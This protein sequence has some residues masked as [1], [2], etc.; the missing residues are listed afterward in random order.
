[1]FEKFESDARRVV[2]LAQDEARLLEH[3]WIGTEHLLLGVLALDG[4]VAA[5]LGERGV[6]LDGVRG[7]VEEIIGPDANPP[8]G[9]HL[10]FTPRAKTVLELS[11]REALRLDH[12]T[13]GPAHILLGLVREGEGVA[14]QLLARLTG[15]LHGVQAL[16]EGLA[17]ETEAAAQASR[18]AGI[19]LADAAAAT[20]AL[21][22]ALGDDV[23]IEGFLVSRSGDVQA[24]VQLPGQSRPAVV[25]VQ[26]TDRGW[27][28][29]QPPR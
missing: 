18:A 20:A 1:M 23:P 19:G 27:V 28:V 5:A 25:T 29:V 12:R 6:S 26:R 14:C 11:F 8:H 16:A 13:I 15:D 7:E 2:V 21:V 9:R 24:S 4:P 22:E 17:G 3:G 10:P